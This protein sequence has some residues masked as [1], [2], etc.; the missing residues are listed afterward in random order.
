MLR[1]VADHGVFAEALP[2]GAGACILRIAT[3]PKG[4]GLGDQNPL[5]QDADGPWHDQAVEVDPARIHLP[6]VIGVLEDDDFTHLEFGLVGACDVR[7]VAAHLDHPEIAVPV[8]GDLH[9]I[10]DE[11]FAGDQVDA[12]SGLDPKRLLRRVGRERR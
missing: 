11:W 8:E 1:I 6:V 3:Q 5:G 2:N 7:H 10:P 12:M 9:G 4:A